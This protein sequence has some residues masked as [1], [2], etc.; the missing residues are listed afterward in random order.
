MN[1]PH[2]VVVEVQINALAVI[3]SQIGKQTADR[4]R[5]V[6]KIYCTVL[7][8]TPLSIKVS[9]LFCR[10]EKNISSKLIPWHLIP[11]NSYY[12]MYTVPGLLEIQICIDAIPTFSIRCRKTRPKSLVFSYIRVKKGQILHWN[13]DLEKLKKRDTKQIVLS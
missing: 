11:H 5:N 10:H 7:L 2:F 13:C 4:Q 12:I 3:P 9:L 1:F 8:C 6:K